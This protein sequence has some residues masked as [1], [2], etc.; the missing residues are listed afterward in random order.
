L[1][2]LAWLEI[3]TTKNSI[4]L[5][6]EK[7]HHREDLGRDVNSLTAFWATKVVS[8]ARPKMIYLP[9]PI[10]EYRKSIKV[11]EDRTEGERKGRKKRY[12]PQ[13]KRWVCLF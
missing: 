8:P 6:T 1:A 11:K 7:K 2:Y 12:L 10:L 13:Y 5:R 3:P 4:E 9:I